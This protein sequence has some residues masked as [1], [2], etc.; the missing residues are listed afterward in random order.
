[1]ADASLPSDQ[2]EELIRLLGGVAK[3]KPQE[4]SATPP[5]AK[6]KPQAPPP[7]SQPVPEPEE[8]E[9]PATWEPLE[10]AEPP[11]ITKPDIIE[12]KLIDPEPVTTLRS[13]RPND[14]IRKEP[15]NP[16]SLGVRRLIEQF[17][18]TV[19]KIL[20]DVDKD[21]E[22]TEAAL[23]FFETTVRGTTD[24]KGISPYVDGW[25]R[26]LQTK[27]E[28]GVT[29]ASVL[30]SIAKLIAAGKSN[31]LIINLGEIKKGSLDLETLLSQPLKADET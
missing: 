23:T 15:E 8:P 7:P 3:S 17:G 29:R 26:L 31:D 10:D 4:L 11:L 16:D 6:P 30:D 27:S 21:R 9:E 12:P 1:M 13:A 19:G 18:V 28:L 14:L 24:R 22:Q 2:D 20:A 5:V 25:A